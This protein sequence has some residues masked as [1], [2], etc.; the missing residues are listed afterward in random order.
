METRLIG[1]LYLPVELP[2]KEK[3]EE[4]ELDEIDDELTLEDAEATEHSCAEC[5]TYIG[6]NDDIVLLMRVRPSVVE[7]DL[8]FD[9]IWEEDP[10]LDPHMFMH[11]ECFEHVG[12]EVAEA[13]GDEPPLD[14]EHAILHCDYCSA[15]IRMGEICVTA[16]L[17]EIALSARLTN[18]TTFV[19]AVEKDNSVAAPYVIC[20]PCTFHL[21]EISGLLSWSDLSQK[22]ECYFCTKARCWRAGRCNCDC[23][24]RKHG[25]TR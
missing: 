9:P 2:K 19:Q 13:A 21:V 25:P 7:G 10:A 16:T 5:E 23:H 14:E 24:K 17:G 18:T 1:G 4:Q 8:T 20:L 6:F 12:E 3:Q 11:Y 15:N 22:G